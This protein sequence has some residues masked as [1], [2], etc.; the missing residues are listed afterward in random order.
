MRHFK[1]AGK[2]AKTR[3]AA[4]QDRRSKRM[5]ETKQGA[6]PGTAAQARQLKAWLK[7]NGEKPGA[8]LP[9]LQKA[10]EIYGYVPR[11][12]QQ[13]IADALHKPLTEIYGVSTFYSQFNLEPKGRNR[14]SVCLG[15]ACYIKG[16]GR[17]Y[18]LLQEK[19]GI[20]DGGCTEVGR[21]SLDACRCLGCCGMAPVMMVNEDVYGSLTGDELDA[22]LAKYE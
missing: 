12:V 14:I 16:G 4:G 11:E 10:Q 13:L 20:G 3:T 5:K 21:F 9:A 19:L 18:Q 2:L 6:L 7:E 8:A 22:I 1:K 15:T 17:I